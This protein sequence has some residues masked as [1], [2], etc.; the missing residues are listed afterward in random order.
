MKYYLLLGV[1]FVVLTAVD[2]FFARLFAH[3]DLSITLAFLLTIALVAPQKTRFILR[4]LI[5]IVLVCV[6]SSDTLSAVNPVVFFIAYVVLTMLV[7][8]IAKNVPRADDTK[9]F[10]MMVFAISFVFRFMMG[11]I[12]NRL[13]SDVVLVILLPTGISAIF[14]TVCAVAIAYFL[15]MPIGQKFGKLLF[16]DD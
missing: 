8:V 6:L 9:I 3:S 14:T 16:N 11:L 7:V 2:M 15:D 13:G 12:F 10:V 5:P 4:S 1:I